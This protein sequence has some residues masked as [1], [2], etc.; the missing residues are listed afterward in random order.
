MV[1][2]LPILAMAQEPALTNSLS[3]KLRSYFEMYVGWPMVSLILVSIFTVLALILTRKKLKKSNLP[4]ALI[5]L[6]F[7]IWYFYPA[8]TYKG[9]YTATLEWPW[10][11][12]VATD[13]IDETYRLCGEDDE[14]PDVKLVYH[15]RPLHRM[16]WVELPDPLPEMPYIPIKLGWNKLHRPVLKSGWVEFK[17]VKKGE[18]EDG[19]D[20]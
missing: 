8:F 3:F 2:T 14:S 17:K 13:I 16:L 19:I 11:G 12:E 4:I 5:F 7:S 6:L 9:S 1:L 15:V 10:T 20:E 18:P